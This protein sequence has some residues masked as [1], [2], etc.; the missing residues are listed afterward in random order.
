MNKKI[1][2]F[3]LCSITVLGLLNFSCSGRVPVG[4][5]NP[6]PSDAPK[7]TDP[8]AP[9]DPKPGAE[10]DIK[11]LQTFNPTFAAGMK[12]T[13]LVSKTTG[14]VVSKPE[15]ISSEIVSVADD[16]I[17]AK[18]KDAAGIKEKSLK[19]VDF[20]NPM[21]EQ[22]ADKV[23]FKFVGKED[24]KVTAGTYKAAAKISAISAAGIFTGWLVTGVGTVKKTFVDSKKVTTTTELK[25]FKPK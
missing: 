4:G 12:Y 24:I 19:I 7:P 5:F 17:K 6:K 10:V 15:E 18:V 11:Y 16:T 14:S 2:G 22:T 21:P 9:V 1:T 8:P 13:S 25:E 3:L 20:T 23:K